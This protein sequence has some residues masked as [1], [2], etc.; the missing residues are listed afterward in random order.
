MA[1][2]LAYDIFKHIFMN[3]SDTIPIFQLNL[4]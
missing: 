2:I 1:A 3:E 4:W